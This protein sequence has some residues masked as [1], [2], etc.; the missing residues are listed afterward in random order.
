VQ[1]NF[2]AV[3][4]L[5]VLPLVYFG[6][7]LQLYK[8]RWARWAAWV[9]ILTLLV[10]SFPVAGVDFLYIKRL[11][12]FL[13]AAVVI[14]MLLRALKVV[15]FVDKRRYTRILA[16]LATASVVIY[17][18]FFSFHG[19]HTFIHY[20]DVAHYYLGSKYFKELG[21]ANLY[22]AMLR[23]EAEV[24][25]NHF[26]AIEAR[27]L[28]TYELVHIRDLLIKSDPVKE[29]FTPERWEAFKKDVSF[30][31]EKL[32]AQYGPILKDHGFNPSPFWVVLGGPL[33]NLVPPGSHVGILILTLLDPLLLAASFFALGWVFGAEVVLLCIIHFCVIYGA[34]FGWTGGAFLR[35]M[36]F[37]GLVT[38]ICALER[39]K[40]VLAGSLL[41]GASFLRIFPAAFLAG[42]AFKGLGTFSNTDVSLPSTG[43]CWA[44]SAPPRPCFCFSALP[45]WEASSPGRSS[46]GIWKLM[47]R[48]SHPTLWDS[49]IF[50]PTRTSPR[51]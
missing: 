26:K 24:Y 2:V 38:S 27:D 28:R 11:N 1:S 22:N 23:A 32:G 45:S 29:A 46:T 40:Y 3:V 12:L 17:F 21:Y 8:K 42:I 31:R 25:D 20:H 47:W 7:R 19:E 30:F 49:P 14:L 39:K 18:N 48:T 36:W 35:Y 44:R 10:L 5:G 15:W 4:I 37:F 9:L 43:R 51:W 34:T 16:G 41:A 50:W 33:A 6:Y 13:A